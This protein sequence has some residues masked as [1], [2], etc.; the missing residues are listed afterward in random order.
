MR[1]SRLAKRCTFCA[2]KSPYG[3][4][5]RIAITFKPFSIRI[6]NLVSGGH[7][8]AVEYTITVDTLKFDLLILHY[9]VVL[10]EVGHPREQQPKF[11]LDIISPMGSACGNAEFIKGYTIG[12]TRYSN[13]EY[14]PWSKLGLN[15][16]P[17]HGQTIRIRLT[18]RDCTPTG[19]YGYGYFT[20]RCGSKRIAHYVCKDGNAIMLEAPPGFQY[21][22]KKNGVPVSGATNRYFFATIDGSVYTCDCIFDNGMGGRCVF[23]A[24]TAAEF[25]RTYPKAE[26]TQTVTGIN[27][28][29][30]AHFD[31]LS[32]VEPDYVKIDSQRWEFHDG[33]VTTVYNPVKKYPVPGAYPVTLIIS[34]NLG[35][36]Y[37]SVYQ[38]IV[39]IEPFRI[40][41]DIIGND[42]VCEGSYSTLAVNK[43][44]VSYTWNTGDTTRSIV[45]DSM[46]TKKY[47]VTVTDTNGCTFAKSKT[48]E[49]KVNPIV[50]FDA[51]SCGK[52][53][54]ND[55]IYTESGSYT[56]VFKTKFGCDSTVTLNLK[57]KENFVKIEQ[58]TTDFCNT[59]SADLH[60][61]TEL[62]NVVWNNE[63]PGHWT[64]VHRPGIHRVVASE[65]YCESTDSIAFDICPIWIPN[66]F[67]PKNIDGLND[68]F[69]IPR[70]SYLIEELEILIFNRW[71]KLVFK[72]NDV[73]FKWDGRDDGKYDKSTTYT[74]LLF[75]TD[76]N[77]IMQRLTGTVTVL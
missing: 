12:W 36:C 1:S 55:S 63:T 46:Q 60:A 76:K 67:S 71:G 30:Y 50:E 37:D 16:T 47:I 15:L 72:S 58:V 45:I 28:E 56:Q 31:N 29:Y 2:S 18:A 35:T 57:M 17:Y 48:V 7:S 33:T 24:V 32:I 11:Q 49:V 5:W 20:L 68:Q 66:A 19:H 42:V 43:P 69:Y 14:K 62:D 9:A 65:A 26:Y 3:I 10:Q 61:L 74:Y 8:D 25:I 34:T 39:R 21:Q 59:F 77:G 44:F 70:A 4:G 53:I 51:I 73:N 54:W 41:A 38:R 64:T 6:S 75:M 22:W 23:E 40:N 52:Y 13:G 27:C